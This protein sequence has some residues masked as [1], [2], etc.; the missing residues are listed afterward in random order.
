M[1]LRLVCNRPPMWGMAKVPPLLP[2]PTQVRSSKGLRSIQPPPRLA[3]ARLWTAAPGLCVGGG[4][5]EGAN[6]AC[7]HEVTLTTHFDYTLEIYS[8]I[9]IYIYIYI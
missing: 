8:D 3:W 6:N 7:N 2:S 4:R 5:G 9:Y 1:A